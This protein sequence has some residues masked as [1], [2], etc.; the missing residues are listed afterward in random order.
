M[1]TGQEMH[2]EKRQRDLKTLLRDSVE[3]TK[4]KR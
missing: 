4:V 1:R 2:R 3:I